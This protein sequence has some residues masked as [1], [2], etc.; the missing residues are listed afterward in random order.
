MNFKTISLILIIT[1]FSFSKDI[2]Q[3][4]FLDTL[5]AHYLK[6]ETLFLKFKIET[7][8]DFLDTPIVDSGTV[9]TDGKDFQIK[10]S[11]LE[12]VRLNCV[13]W[14]YS[15]INDQV[16]ISDNACQD[17]N[18]NPLE[19]IASLFDWKIKKVSLDKT[20]PFQK[21]YKIDFDPVDLFYKKATLF[22]DAKLNPSKMSLLDLGNVETLYSF[23]SL[24]INMKKTIEFKNE[25]YA[26][27]IDL[28][29]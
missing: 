15:Q 7:K 29:K 17:N 8:K 6:I 9:Y 3:S 1:T 23:D 27:V 19:K 10:L 12:I 28:R 26:E 4:D 11:Q 2:S 20:Y 25:R 5:F 13:L 18:V 14:K 21:L 16:I 24:Q 22:V